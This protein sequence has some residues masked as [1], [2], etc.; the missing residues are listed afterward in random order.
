M[1]ER[2][3]FRVEAIESQHDVTDGKDEGTNFGI[4]I[5][6]SEEGLE[7]SRELFHPATRKV[8]TNFSEAAR[9]T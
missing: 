1:A 5:S 2:T 8:L 6:L 4:S 3:E 9:A 7:V